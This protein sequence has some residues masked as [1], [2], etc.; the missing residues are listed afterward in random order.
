MLGAIIGDIVGSR[1]EFNN[2]K[3]KE[4]ELFAEDCRPT[5]DSIMTLAVAKAIMETYREVEPDLGAI[6]KKFYTQLREFVIRDMREIGRKYPN[7]GFGGMFGKWIFSDKPEPINSFGNGAAMRVSPVGFVAGSRSD[8]MNLAEAVTDVTHN[9][10]E[11]I[12]GAEATAVAIYMSRRGYVKNEI[13]AQMRKYYPSLGFTV[14]SIRDTYE[15]NETCQETV[16]QAIVAFLESNSFEDAIRTAVSLGGDSDTL[17]AVTG[18]I[19]E[20]YY[21]I[22]DDIKAKA[23]SYLDDELHAIY[24]DWTAFTGDYSAENRFHVLTKFIPKIFESMQYDKFISESESES[25]WR[26]IESER[27]IP[28]NLCE[29]TEVFVSEFI[30]YSECHPEYELEEFVAILNEHDLIWADTSMMNA[31]KE[32]LDAQCAL[33]LITGVIRIDHDDPGTLAR[34]M[35]FGTIQTWLDR[36]MIM[37]ITHGRPALEEMCLSF[38]RFASM[39]ENHWLSFYDG[40]A[41]REIERFME[42]PLIQEF[43]VAETRALIKAIE[44][45]RLEYWYDE[46]ENMS[47]LDG[48]SWTLTLRF[49]E[50]PP[51]TW[52]G[53]NAYPGNFSALQAVFG[54][55]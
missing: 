48:K 2:H 19:A 22:P 53:T 30:A 43:S 28:M 23:L 51:V 10:E 9:H 29:L 1:F 35:E 45:I 18:S 52:R 36:L 27:R 37:D 8:A 25:S 17:A 4:F 11:G 34:Y 20:A 6:D 7:C 40:T 33:A 39:P 32:T 41:M 14:D 5:D 3:D 55:K 49:G 26:K 54:M 21:G 16:P 31:D 46:Y 50:R 24:V 15:F 38:S 47:V 13:R 44:D 12:K 42:E